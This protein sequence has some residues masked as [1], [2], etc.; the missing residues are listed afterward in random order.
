[1]NPSYI[2][3]NI[4]TCP[5]GFSTRLGGVSEG[6]FESLNLGRIENGDDP[7][8]VAE[9][10]R[11]F[12]SA[13]GIDTS[14]FVHGKQVHGNAVR[15]VSRADAHDIR[16]PAPFEGVDGYVTDIPGLPLVIFTA[17]CV[18]LLLQ[19]PKAG[20][21]GAIHSGWRGTAADIEKSAVDAMCRLG[22]DAREI[23]AAI[24]PCICKAC[25][26]TGAE[27]PA[28]LE[29]LLGGDAEGLYQPD[30]EEKGKYRVDLP[31]AVERRLLQLGLRPEHIEQ[32]GECTMCHPEKYWSH[33]AL[34]L[35][36][37][38]QANIIM[39]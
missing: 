21:I 4:L 35:A 11:I 27:V 31:G 1:M 16:T 23:R 26:Q 15:V 10:W 17:D 38:S 25:F 30:R 37:G 12:G 9:N 29:A 20:I 13:L 3:S 33:R 8:K 24:G 14:A 18:P 39:L 22:A 28:A 19:E 7:E 36:R 32:T 6:I 2:Q 34:G 5:H